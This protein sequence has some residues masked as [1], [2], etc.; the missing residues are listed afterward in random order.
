MKYLLDANV[1]AELR[2]RARANVHVVEWFDALDS[3]AIL[4]SVVT[5]GEIRK[6]IDSLQRRDPKAAL[7][8]EHWLQRLLTLH[9]NSILPIDLAVAEEWGRLNVPDPLPVIDG[10]LA[11]TARVHDL[12]L[13]TR[14]VKDIA[15]TGVSFINPFVAS[16]S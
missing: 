7:V 16:G 5:I 10:L 6:G 3:D 11:A 4:I 12:T 9:R 1:L 8:L 13:A 15:R 2:K 14:N